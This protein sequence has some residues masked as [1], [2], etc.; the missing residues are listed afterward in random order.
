MVRKSVWV[1]S[2]EG[3]PREEVG[4]GLEGGERHGE[5]V[6]SSLVEEGQVREG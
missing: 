2:V 3:G 6:V 5:E 1:V 4:G